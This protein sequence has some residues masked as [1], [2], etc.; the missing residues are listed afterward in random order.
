MERWARDLAAELGLPFLRREARPR[1]GRAHGSSPGYLVV[2]R[3]RLAVRAGAQRLIYHPGMAVHRIRTLQAGGTDPMVQAMGLRG[4][5]RILDATLGPGADALVAAFAAGAGGRVTGLEKVPVLAVLVREGLRS[6]PWEDDRLKEAAARI[7]VVAADHGE[8][9]A[10][11]PRGSFDVVYFD[12][13]FDR[14]LEGSS[15]MA[16]WRN[17]ADP[18]PLAPQALEAA[19]RVAARRVVIK[20]RRSSPR[21]TALAPPQIVAGRS[22]RVV[23]GVWAAAGGEDGAGDGLSRT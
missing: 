23:Y 22:S 11:C 18:S 4:G 21:L 9:L 14:A 2:E 13:M 15:A 8:F 6:Y 10:R 3:T 16:A 5:E 19:R 12:V 7:E 20:E 17:V 1:P